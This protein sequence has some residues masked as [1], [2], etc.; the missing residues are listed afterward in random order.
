[1]SDVS[2]AKLQQT[3]ATALHYQASGEVCNIASD[4]FTAD[5]RMQIYR[6]NFVVS[7]SEVLAA[8]YPMVSALVGEECFN[9]MARQHVLNNPL[10]SG[11]VSHY[12]EHFS[13][14]ISHFPAVVEAAPYAAEVARFEWCIDLAQQQQGQI[15]LSNQLLP[16]AKL[17]EL[18]PAQQTS[19]HLHLLPG[20]V[21]FQS[22]YAVYSL[23]KAIADN[24]FDDLQLHQAEQGFIC[25]SAQGEVWTQKLDSNAF[26][27]LQYLHSGCTLGEIP[28]EQLQHINLIFD[29]NVIAGFTLAY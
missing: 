9:Q 11:D 5:E 16:L 21:L 10:S 4:T 17:A 7:L 28:P 26:D 18:E 15:S 25:C 8:T 22:C 20:M 29:S 14:S 23:Q 24:Q 12:G 27:L 1:M 2:L 3:F 19:I 13:D 6:N